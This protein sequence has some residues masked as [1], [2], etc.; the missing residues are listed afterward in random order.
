MKNNASQTAP[1][2]SP[3]N[4]KSEQVRTGLAELLAHVSSPGFYGGGSLTVS[5]QDG[6]IQQVKITAERS[7]R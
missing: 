1:Q 4:S 7:L 6:H 5:V 3:R 2:R